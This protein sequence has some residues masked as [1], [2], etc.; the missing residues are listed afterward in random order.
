MTIEKP[1][2]LEVIEAVRVL[3]RAGLWNW[4]PIPVPPT[5]T[6]KSKVTKTSVQRRRHRR[7]NLT[8]KEIKTMISDRKLGLT[9]KGVAMMHK[10]SPSTVSRVTNST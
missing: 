7:A 3:D 9:I 2:V 5:T 10:C 8:K 4:G 1:N 6:T